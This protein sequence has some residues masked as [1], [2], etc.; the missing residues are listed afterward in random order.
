MKR[1]FT[2]SL[3]AVLLLF[4]SSGSMVYA[5]SSIDQEK[6]ILAPDQVHEG[7]MVLSA[8]KAIIDGTINGDL[9][10]FAESIQ[11]NGNVN[12]DVIAF[13]AE[14][15]IH[16]KIDGNL[17]AFTQYATVSG[18]ISR[19]ITSFAQQTSITEKGTVNGSILTFSET[20][21]LAGEV[22]KEAN[23]F[24]NNM[25]IAGKLGRGTSLLTVNHLELGSTARVDG[26]LEYTSPSKALIQ[27]GAV[28]SGTEHF[29]KAEPDEEDNTKYI[30]LI[31]VLMF[32]LS[33]IIVWLLLRFL[34]GSTLNRI[35]S[36]FDTKQATTFGFGLVF[37]LSVPVAIL[38]LLFSV[39]GIPTG[40]TLLFSYLILLFVAKIFV[41]SW[42]GTRIV[43]H[44][45]LPI[46]PIFAEFLGIL[47]LYGL[48]K[49]PFVGFLLDL[50]V[51]I[52]FLGAI[53]V[54]IRSIN[55]RAV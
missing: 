39:I 48:L 21:D 15:D 17:R 12:G 7:D 38:I 29:S 31:M 27:P 51:W 6:Y 16:G 36:Q 30:P 26:N 10:V 22:K 19:N 54:T 25:L 55:R 43:K 24:V 8:H 37:F 52:F 33:T 42:A 34:L 46:H 49:I 50:G 13:A 32:L 44:Y 14:T 47:A 23:G 18:S 40:L 20:F 28:L 53:A 2:C 3:L 41:G 1:L 4:I 5:L 9:Y 35:H 11:I 45:N